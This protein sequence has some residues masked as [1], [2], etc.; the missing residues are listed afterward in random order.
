MG[1]LT[2]SHDDIAS[3]IDCYAVRS[4]HDVSSCS[5]QKLLLAVECH[6][7]DALCTRVNDVKTATH[8]K[9]QTRDVCKSCSHLTHLLSDDVVHEHL[10][11]T[12]VTQCKF[13]SIYRSDVIDFGECFSDVVE[14][15]CLDEVSCVGEHLD[16]FVDIVTDDDVMGVC[17]GDAAVVVTFVALYVCSERPLF[18]SLNC[19]W[20]RNVLLERSP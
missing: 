15:D 5:K 10:I 13:I 11:S 3:K 18:Q 14:G 1:V 20:R 2:F 19:E 17:A 8:A 4:P 12:R 6:H 7:N 16:S 9:S